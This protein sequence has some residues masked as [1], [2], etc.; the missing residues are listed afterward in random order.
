MKGHQRVHQRTRH[1]RTKD[2]LD[3]MSSLLM[4]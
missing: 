1:T 4:T 3:P 2:S